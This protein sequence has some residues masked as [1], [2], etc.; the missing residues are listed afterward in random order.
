VLE[1]PLTPHPS[2]CTEFG[3][4]NG[5]CVTGEVDPVTRA[6]GTPITGTRVSG[7][8]V[9]RFTHFGFLLNNAIDTTIADT[10]ASHNGRW[11]SPGSS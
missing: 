4:V 10:E 11:A 8:L 1:P 6:N 3:E 9:R 7:F 5:I 2:V